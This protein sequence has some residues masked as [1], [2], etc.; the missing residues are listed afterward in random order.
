VTLE[1]GKVTSIC[2]A[3]GLIPGPA[4]FGSV[5]TIDVKEGRLLTDQRGMALRVPCDT[6]FLASDGR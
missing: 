2:Y 1:P 4:G 6:S 3:F 5:A